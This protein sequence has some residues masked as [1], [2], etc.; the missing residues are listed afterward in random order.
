MCVCVCVCVRSTLQIENNSSLKYYVYKIKVYHEEK[1]ENT[2][3]EK[4]GEERP[5]MWREHRPSLALIDMFLHEGETS[6]AEKRC[7]GN[8]TGEALLEGKRFRGGN[9]KRG[10]VR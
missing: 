9:L 8:D 10:N 5:A 4:K 3:R 2:D 1:T 7:L 6:E